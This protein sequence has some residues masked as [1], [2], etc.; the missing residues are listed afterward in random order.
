MEVIAEKAETPS[1]IDKVF[2]KELLKTLYYHA[3]RIDISNNNIKAEIVLRLL[4]PEFID[5]GTGTN[6]IAV[7]YSPG[8]DRKFRGGAGLIYKIALDRRG[9]I[10]N[11]T[12]FK[13]SIECPNYFP[14]VYESNMLVICE[15]YVN[16]MDE[17]EF[18][19]NKD[20]ILEVLEDLSHDYIFEDLGWDLKNYENWGY[21]DNGDIVAL[22]IGYV[23]PIRNNERALTCPKCSGQLKP[24]SVYTGFVCQNPTCRTK[25]NFL[26]VRRQMN[27][28]LE[29]QEDKML[30]AARDCEVPDF[31]RLNI[32]G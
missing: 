18:R 12:A 26:D 27:T 4:G 16:L 7:T 3:C 30:L 31:D 11:W 19:M 9:F 5:I 22:D 32:T 15:E 20:Q 25:Y 24:N 17:T 8:P 6:R 14:H 13:R 1:L 23:F 21:R 28:E 29:D 2:S 10:D